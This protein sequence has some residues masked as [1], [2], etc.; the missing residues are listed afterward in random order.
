[1]KE[2]AETANVDLLDSKRVGNALFVSQNK[3]NEFN[4]SND[5]LDFQTRNIPKKG[6][7]NPTMSK[8]SNDYTRYEKSKE[9]HEVILSKH[10]DGD[11]LMAKLNEKLRQNELRR[12]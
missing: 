2:S 11:E 5:A 6:K 4:K 8:T 9:L 1:M 12:L 7:A 3:S 10:K